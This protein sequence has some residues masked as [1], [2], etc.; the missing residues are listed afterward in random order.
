MT[1]IR[2]YSDLRLSALI[3]GYGFVP[4]EVDLLQILKQTR[5]CAIDRSEGV[6]FL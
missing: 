6:T 3:R 4:Y 1:Q 2:N 5:K